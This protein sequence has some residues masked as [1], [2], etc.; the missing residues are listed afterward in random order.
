MTAALAMT[1]EGVPRSAL[2]KARQVDREL[3]RCRQ[4]QRA[5]DARIA[6]LLAEVERDQLWRSLG[7]SSLTRYAREALGYSSSKTS[8]ASCVS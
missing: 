8:A 7:Y 6:Q 5:L 1:R 3:R 4:T 2:R